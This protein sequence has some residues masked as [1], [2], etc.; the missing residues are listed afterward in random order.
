MPGGQQALNKKKL[1]R[2][3]VKSNVTETMQES[4]QNDHSNSKTL[5]ARAPL[6]HIHEQSLLLENSGSKEHLHS[7]SHKLDFAIQN[8]TRQLNM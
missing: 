6:P 1:N 8:Q 5:D 3:Y 4:E 2:K 7:D